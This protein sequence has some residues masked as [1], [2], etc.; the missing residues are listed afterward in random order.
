MAE[1]SEP[2]DAVE[3]R[4]IE[5]REPGRC[6]GCGGPLNVDESATRRSSPVSSNG[7]PILQAGGTDQHV[8]RRS[9]GG[10]RSTETPAAPMEPGWHPPRCPPRIGSSWSR[11]RW[12]RR[13][14][15]FSVRFSSAL[16]RNV[17]GAAGGR[18][19]GGVEEDE[20]GGHDLDCTENDEDAGSD[21]DGVRCDKQGRDEPGTKGQS[22]D[23]G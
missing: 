6:R 5:Y 2:F 18:V 9:R 3:D 21:R 20:C 14:R 17:A 12:E 11:S 15:R 22:T 16:C 19:L 8:G 1:Q 10:S 23:S 13:H 4:V 7:R